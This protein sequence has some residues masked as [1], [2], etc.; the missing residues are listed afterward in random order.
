MRRH[1]TLAA[2]ALLLAGCLSSPASPAPST[3][4]PAPSDERP[5]VEPLRY[6]AMGDSYTIGDELP[7]QVDRWPNQ[8]VR[9]LRPEVQLQ[10]VDNLAGQSHGT[11]DVIEM[12]LP[13]LEELDADL[14]SL[15]VGVNDVVISRLTDEEYRANLLEILDGVDAGDPIDPTAGIAGASLTPPRAGILDL[16]TPDR[17]FLVTT[18]DYT[19]APDR[20]F[21]RPD[22]AARVARFNE[23]L[24]ELAAERSVAVVDIAPISDMVARDPTLITADGLHASA[25]QYA[26]WVELIAPVVRGLV[27]AA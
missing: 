15:Q 19:L 21:D 18:P 16:V 9:A 25:K 8:L 20:R 22:A 1:P 2:M 12:Q 23:I 6:V 26:G 13:V 7:R 24:R 5:A 11:T 10:L 14:V 27:A 17:L 3:A 4:S